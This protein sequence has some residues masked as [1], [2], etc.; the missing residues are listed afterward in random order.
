MILIIVFDFLLSIGYMSNFNQK[1]SYH[2]DVLLI[3][4]YQNCL[5]NDENELKINESMFIEIVNRQI[6]NYT[7]NFSYINNI[8]I[9]YYFNLNM[10]RLKLSYNFHYLPQSI[11]KELRYLDY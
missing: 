4:S 10:V 6:K 1:L 9:K 8:N 7:S 2:L 3:D 11:S 5:I